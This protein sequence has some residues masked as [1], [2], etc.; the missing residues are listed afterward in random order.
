M[1]NWRRAGVLLMLLLVPGQVRAEGIFQIKPVAPGVYAAI[2]QAHRPEN[3]NSA[4]ILLEDGVLVV[5]AASTPSS[6]QQ[7]ISQIRTLTDMPVKYVV[8]THFHWDHYWGNEAFV[9]TWPDVEIISSEATRQD[10][11]RMSLGNLLLARWLKEIPKELET[12]KAEAEKTTNPDKRRNLEERITQWG[13]AVS[14]MKT[15]RSRLPVVTFDRRFVIHD[16]SEQVEIL[17]LGRAHTPGDVVVYLPQKHVLVSGDLLAGDTPYI[18]VVSPYEWIRALEEVRKLD[19]DNLIPG[20]GDVIRGKERL[21]LWKQYL[22]DVMSETERAYAQGKSSAE[23]RDAVVPI[24]KAR[25]AS[26]FAEDFPSAVEG[27]VVT[28]YRMVS[29]E[30]N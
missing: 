30:Q 2:A 7:L 11:Q 10:M 23:T 25:Y 16:G 20:H 14:E 6:A 17:W 15:M 19:F 1:T 18:G 22:A 9:R 3:A 4:I 12:L 21:D 8:N 28:A 27:N 13:A 29:G 5:D 24:L 26:R